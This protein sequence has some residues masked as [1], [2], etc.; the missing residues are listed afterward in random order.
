[1]ERKLKKVLFKVFVTMSLITSGWAT[2]VHAQPTPTYMHEEREDH[3]QEDV[4]T[5]MHFADDVLKNKFLV[6]YVPYQERLFKIE[7]GYRDLVNAY[8]DGQANGQVIPGP[9]ARELLT[10]GLKLQHD[11]NANLADYIEKLKKNLPG[12]VALQAWIVESKLHAASASA[13]LAN[14]PFVQQ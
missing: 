13:Y 4:V 5:N 3:R 2:V 11:R 7:H 12:G 1:M 6:Y 14:V 9:K 8:L 10:R